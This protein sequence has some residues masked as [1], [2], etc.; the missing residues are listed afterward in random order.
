MIF[1][2]M[3]VKIVRAGLKMIPLALAIVGLAVSAYWIGLVHAQREA[4]NHQAARASAPAPNSAPDTATL[5]KQ[6]ADLS[7]QMD[8]LTKAKE[9]LKDRLDSVE[10]VLSI[11]LGT[12]A[13]LTVA[14]GLFAFFSA[15]NYVNQADQAIDR[16]GKAVTAAESAEQ[17]VVR[18]FEELAARIQSRFPMLADTES[19]RVEAFAKLSKLIS[20]L[21]NADENLYAKSDPLTRQEVF[22]IESFSAVQFLTAEARGNELVANLRL[23]GRFYAGKFLSDGQTFLPDFDRSYYYFIL[24]EQKSHRSYGVLNDLGWLFFSVA[25]PPDWDKGRAFFEESLRSKPDQ[26]RALYNLG[27]IWKRRNQAEVKRAREYLLEA[28]RQP[29]WE[30][31]P[32]PSMASHIDYNLACVCDAMADME[33]DPV[34]KSNLL[35]E[36]CDYLDKAAAL[37]TQ[38]RE[39]LDGDLRAGD[40]VTLAGSQPHAHR[41]RGIRAKYRPSGGGMP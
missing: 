24:A 9:S 21:T 5:Q 38:P 26:Q 2:T 17:E 36:C 20:P 41:L 22:A 28:K 4:L 10:W 39:L 34:L 25:K 29:N 12:I 31:A 14:Q 27:T 35:D 13:L 11:V 19:A 16:A 23:L 3:A 30:T 7:N 40:L 15:Q 32:S 33:T 37:G 6:A 18:R 1:S 8:G